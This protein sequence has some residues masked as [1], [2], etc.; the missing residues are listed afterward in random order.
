MAVISSSKNKQ[1]MKVAPTFEIKI[2]IIGPVS[3]GKST[4]L[5]ALLV[6]KYS[7]TALQRTTAG[8][9]FFR[10]NPSPTTTA[11]LS[12]TTSGKGNSP[13]PGWSMIADKH[14]TEDEILEQ[15]SKDNKEL[16]EQENVVERTFDIEG[17]S[18]CECRHDTKLVIV[19]IPGINEAESS[20]KYRNYVTKQWKTFDCVIVVMDAGNG[21]NSEEQVG[22]LEFIQKNLKEEKSL[23]VILLFNKVDDLE[24]TTMDSILEEARTKVASLFDI[25]PKINLANDI[26]SKKVVGNEL[27]HLKN[28]EGLFMPIFLPISARN[29]Y[30]YRLA[31]KVDS[32]RFK[33]LEQK[34]VEVIGKEQIGLRQWNKLTAEQQYDH[35]FDVISD[36]E[37]Y[38]EGLQSSNFASLESILSYCVGGDKTQT[39]L[40]LT[41]INIAM[42]TIPVEGLVQKIEELWVTMRTLT[43]KELKKIP[44][45]LKD[46]FWKSFEAFVPTDSDKNS[47]VNT[48]DPLRLLIEYHELVGGKSDAEESESVVT[49]A[50]LY[51]QCTTSKFLAHRWSLKTPKE[52]FSTIAALE[53][54]LFISSKQHFVTHLGELRSVLKIEQH[55]FL[56]LFPYSKYDSERGTTYLPPL[57]YDATRGKWCTDKDVF[58][59]VPK[60]EESDLALAFRLFC[61]WMER[62]E[63]HKGL[64]KV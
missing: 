40:L 52:R 60:T 36:P 21:V 14:D 9:N 59:E 26:V 49:R 35:A 62:T 38:Q 61:E 10:L 31:S 15:I 64:E 20:S 58:I 27:Q 18:L 45:G 47:E 57:S 17:V 43:G 19:D 5:N 29:A 63:N 8:V 44:Q 55:R 51:L 1:S 42:E 7:E 32:T 25:P 11:S 28:A 6:G 24:F 39:D 50:V 33:Q 2:A 16:R 13:P 53:Q 3:A 54:I 48:S 12:D 23:T 30:I 22:I 56:R 46:A 37:V 34:L 41:Q 4:L